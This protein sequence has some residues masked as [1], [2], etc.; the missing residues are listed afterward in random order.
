MTEKYR[1]SGA[2]GENSLAR[3]LNYLHG[4]DATGM[5]SLAKDG[6]TKRLYIKDGDIVFAASTYEGDRLG[7]A[8]LRAGKIT[9]R[10]FEAASKVVIQTGR[11]FGGVL[12]EMGS[13]KPRDLFWGVK[14]QVQEIVYS[15]FSWT[16][17]AYEFIPGELPAGEVITLHMST[18]NL[19]L[20]GI[21]RIDDWTRISRG[22]PPM[23]SVMRLTGDQAR[24][25]QDVDFPAEEKHVLSLFDGRRTIKEV[26][27][28]SRLSDFDALRAVYVFYSIG[29]LEDKSGRGPVQ[30]GPEEKPE[31]AA[32]PGQETGGEAR[33]QDHYEVLNV[34]KDAAPAEIKAAY[35]RLARLYHPDPVGFAWDVIIE[36]AYKKL[37]RLYLPEEQEQEGMKQMTAELEEMFGK[38]NEAYKVLSDESSRWEYDLSLTSVMTDKGSAT[39]ACRYKKP[40]DTVRA[41]EAFGT[42]VE[43]FKAGDMEK[44]ASF[45]QDAVELDCTG[46]VYYSHLALAL[47]L[48]P[49]RE[50]EAEE[51]MLTAVELEPNNPELRA[52]LG[53]LYS[54]VGMMDK[55]RVA[56]KDALALDPKNSK[57]IRALERMK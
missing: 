43:C 18:A 32:A 34:E 13:L 14:F 56:F 51:A 53:L 26:L 39:A 17:C 30:E 23:D 20:N 38:V 8:L 48:R 12:V 54:R 2:I 9:V 11:R 15:L 47:L 50:A 3:L 28:E 37:A 1:L 45:F 49:R 35:Q 24:L 40:K 10:Q 27:A 33:R 36:D 29:M 52:N 57:A 46:A 16:D 5:L 42:G 19:I 21:K 25:F 22:I 44:A 41:W 4:I 6:I 7:E 31:D 55:A